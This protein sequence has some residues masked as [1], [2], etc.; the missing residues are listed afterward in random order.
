MGSTKLTFGCLF[1]RKK[2]LFSSSGSF[3][4]LTRT[5]KPLS[6]SPERLRASPLRNLSEYRKNNS[7]KI[8]MKG[9][10]LFVFLSPSP[11]PLS[12][13][14]SARLFSGSDICPLLFP[15]W[16]A[17][18]V[19]PFAKGMGKRWYRNHFLTSC[20][21]SYGPGLRR[22]GLGSEWI[23][24]RQ[25]Q[26]RERRN[27]KDTRQPLWTF[28]FLCMPADRPLSNSCPCF[29]RNVERGLASIFFSKQRLGVHDLVCTA[30]LKNDSVSTPVI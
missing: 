21:F 23:Y 2:S 20:L 15:R 24:Y 18:F 10:S 5:Y 26:H 9:P 7:K 8:L 4:Y 25:G 27:Q 19:T 11:C 29:L 28:S 30:I 1:I 13:Q 12:L 22:T 6:T 3:F 17:F 16:A 14:L